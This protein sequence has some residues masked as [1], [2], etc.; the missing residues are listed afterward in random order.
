MTGGTVAVLGKTGRN[1]A[2]GM[3]GGVAYVYDED[4]QFAS[5]CNTAMVS[6]EK[7]QP[8]AQQEAGGQGRDH[9]RL[10]SV[11]LTNG[12]VTI[13]KLKTSLPRLEI[14]MMEPAQL[15]A[16]VAVLRL[17]SFDRAARQLGVTSSAISQRIRLLEEQIGAALIIRSQPCEPTESGQ[18]LLRYAEEV[19]LLE[20]V[21]R[22]DLGL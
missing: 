6:L 16:L 5:R 10:Q 17:G 20:Q 4:G 7:V 12:L 19:G 8:A 18:R 9:E 21:L 1:F 11:P 15:A 13:R 2:A 3:S 14:L 22:Q